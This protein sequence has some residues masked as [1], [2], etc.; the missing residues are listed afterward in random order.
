MLVKALANEQKL[1][2]SPETKHALL[3]NLGWARLMQGSYQDAEVKLLEAIDLQQSANVKTNIAA[4]H[5]LLA[6]VM[7]EKKEKKS[8]LKEW[9]TCIQYAD[10]A[11]SPDEDGWIITAQKRLKEEENRK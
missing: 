8:A 6:E 5:C 7:E 3:K 10:I 9:E 2:P 4:P 1:K 11:S